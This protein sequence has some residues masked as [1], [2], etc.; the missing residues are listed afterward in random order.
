MSDF[1]TYEYVV[2]QKMTGKW[3]AKKLS[4][5][6]GYVLFI[7]LWFVFGFVTK[8]F[9]LLC[10][11]PVTLWILIF[12]TWRYVKVEHEYSMVSGDITFSDVYGG[13]SRKTLISFKIKNCSL[14]APATEEYIQQ[15]KNF[16]P[17]VVIEARS[18]ASAPDSYLALVDMDGK[19]AAVYFEAT[20]KAL[21]IFKFYN[22]GCTVAAKVSF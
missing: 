19:R 1:Q 6:L 22:A 15:A 10:L 16:A 13:K 7:I 11:M 5:L 17:D 14:I 12:F 3:K 18:S 2:A 4:L 9:P 21:K 8:F 20:E